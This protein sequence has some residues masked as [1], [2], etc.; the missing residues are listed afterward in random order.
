[1]EQMY[2]PNRPSMERSVSDPAASDWNS[3]APE[4]GLEES[5]WQQMNLGGRDS[6]PE[7]PGEPDCIYYMRTGFCGYGVRCRFNHPRDR[8]SVGGVLRGGGEYPE[9]VGQPLCQFFMKTGSCKFGASCKFHHPR[10][11]GGPASPVS[12]NYY[13][14]PLRPGEKECSYYVKTGQCK[15]GVTCKFHHPQPTG[16]SMPAPAPAFYPTVQSPSVPSPPQYGGVASWQVAR[17]PLIPGSYVQGPYGALMFSPGM[18]PI[19]GWSTYPPPVSPVA[20]PG[21][22]H[23]VGT[24]SMYGLTHQL[25]PSAPAYQGPYSPIS[26]VAGPSSSS[27]KE[28]MFPERPGQPEC[29]FYMRTG[30][31]KYGSTCRYHHPPEWSLPKTTCALS[32]IGLPLRPGARPCSFYAQNG[33]CKFGPTCKFDHP[34]GTLSYSPSASSLADMPVAPY[35]VGF[36]MAKLAPSSSSSELRTEFMAGSS[37]DSFSTRMPSSSDNTSSGS[38]GSIFSKGGGSVPQ[39]HVQLLGQSSAP[40]SSSSSMGHG[41]E[42]L[43]SS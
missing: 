7:R 37:K 40:S 6:Y 11:G 27:Q 42:S 16:L 14:Y 2:G 18:V 4:A 10:Y 21:T 19:P 34:M 31:C 1:M 12:L 28:H 9:R 39:L 22:Q 38:V 41:S 25:S 20:S 17:P 3:P 8:S 29:Q 13:G 26:S 23:S 15:F 35:P 32:P 24:G 30:D 43:G 33:I 5:M 36:S